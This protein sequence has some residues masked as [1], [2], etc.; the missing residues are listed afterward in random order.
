[1]GRIPRSSPKASVVGEAEDE[2]EMFY[3]YILRSEKNGQLYHGSTSDLK[4][5]LR[6]HNAG[7]SFATKPYVPWKLVFYSA[8]ETEGLAVRFEKYLKS[9]SGWAFARKR[10]LNATCGADGSNH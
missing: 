7:Q 2:G 6:Q 4:T 3:A 1:M 5:R 8:F 9:S 10:L